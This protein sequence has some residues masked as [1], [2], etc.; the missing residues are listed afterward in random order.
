MIC[1]HAKASIMKIASQI[2]TDMQKMRVTDMQKMKA[3]IMR[4]TDNDS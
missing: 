4:V 2:T 1:K 3:S